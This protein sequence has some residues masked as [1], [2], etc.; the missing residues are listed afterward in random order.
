[1]GVPSHKTMV[2]PLTCASRGL[3]LIVSD[4]LRPGLALDVASWGNPET[5]G[6]GRFFEL[7]GLWQGLLN[8]HHQWGKPWLIMV[9]N[10]ESVDDI[11]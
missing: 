1:M 2:M 6:G 9:N 4:E 8:V 3:C 10:G 11:C 5:Q 7:G